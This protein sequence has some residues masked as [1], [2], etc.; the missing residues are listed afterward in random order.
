MLTISLNTIQII[1]EVIHRF[2]FCLLFPNV[3][4]CCL[5]TCFLKVCH[6]SFIKIFISIMKII[7]NTVSVHNIFQNMILPTTTNIS[8]SFLSSLLIYH[9]LIFLLHLFIMEPH[10][11]YHVVVLFPGID[12]ISCLMSL[13][14]LS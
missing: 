2:L 5:L 1:L 11:A 7:Q 3:N 4:V 6:C 12:L 8:F 9:S 14:C 13:N 10:I